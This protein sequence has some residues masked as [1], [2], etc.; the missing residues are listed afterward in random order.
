MRNTSLKTG[1]VSAR[2]WT[3]RDVLD[4]QFTHGVRL[5]PRLANSGD[6]CGDELLARLA[7]I[8]ADYLNKPQ[9][10]GEIAMPLVILRTWLRWRMQTETYGSTTNAP[11]H[12][13]TQDALDIVTWALTQPNPGLLVVR[14]KKTRRV[15]A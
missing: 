11:R 4:H 6:C 7:G 2:D 3:S 10:Q 14:V 5:A 1:S 15:A 13:H 8:V 12:A 9:C